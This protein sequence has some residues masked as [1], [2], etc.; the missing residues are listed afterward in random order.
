MARETVGDLIA[1]LDPVRFTGAAAARRRRVSGYSTDS[2]SLTTGDVFVALRGERFD[3]HDFI[4]R[5]APLASA[6]VVD[7]RWAD[8]QTR[9]PALPLVVVDDTLEAYGRIATAH[10]ERFDI[11]VVA[12]AGSNGKTTTKDLVAQVL[13]TRYRVLA[14]EGNLNNLIGVPATMLRI[15]PEHEVAVIEIGTNMPGEIARLCDVLRP[16]HG[17]ITNIGREHL[18][19]LGSIEGVAAEEGSLFGFLAHTGGTAFVNGDDPH[20]RTLARQVRSRIVYGRRGRVD[21]RGTVLGLDEACRPK[22]RITDR[23][24]TKERT[25]DTQLG[26][27]GM[28]TAFNALAAATVGLGLK[29]PITKVARALREFRPLN[30]RSGYGRL[31]FE[32]LSNG[33]RLLNDTYN[34][35]PESMTVALET[36]AAMRPGNEGRRIAV[37]ADMRELGIHSAREHRSIGLRI[38]EGIGGVD[39]ALFFGTEMRRACRALQS[40]D[41]WS[42]SAR[43]FRDRETLA[44]HLRRILLPT[45]VVLIK[46]SRGLEME[47]VITQLKQG[48]H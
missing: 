4:A 9:F 28:H 35:N 27:P 37:L 12:I 44:E 19:L 38:A 42:G 32:T 15:A 21:V 47:K 11:P 16:T 13:A 6:A 40:S 17:L 20:L 33:V 22:L 1:T 31:A 29:V 25:T 39:V 26:T 41:A 8:A 24:G 14:T 5:V 2:R 34:A 30:Y 46:G 18:E 10:R 43:Y 36:L 48:P 23:R 3:G 7:V 45:D